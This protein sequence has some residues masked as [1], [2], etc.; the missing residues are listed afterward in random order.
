VGV[1]YRL[2]VQFDRE[3]FPHAPADGQY[4]GYV[5]RFHQVEVR[6][7]EQIDKYKFIEYSKLVKKEKSPESSAPPPTS[8]QSSTPHSTTWADTPAIKMTK[9]L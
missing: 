7:D 8:S 9:R 3:K 5:H 6:P 2:A 1:N 4:P